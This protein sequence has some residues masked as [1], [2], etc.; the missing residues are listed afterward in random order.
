M[1]IEKSVREQMQDLGWVNTEI[2][3]VHP[4]VRDDDGDLIAY[5]TEADAIWGCDLKIEDPNYEPPEPHGWEGGFA[6]N[7]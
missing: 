4:D 7:H 5:D 2:G 3:W 1:S 6:P